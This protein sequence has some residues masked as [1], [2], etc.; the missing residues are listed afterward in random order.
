MQGCIALS[1]KLD[2][3]GVKWDR[4]RRVMGLHIK[5]IWE[6]GW[7][8]GSGSGCGASLGVGW[9]CMT[10]RSNL[11]VDGSGYGSGVE[12]RWGDGGKME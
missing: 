9:G 4:S 3:A 6:E 12:D 10:S 11:G 2:E 5:G 7:V 8:G 1:D